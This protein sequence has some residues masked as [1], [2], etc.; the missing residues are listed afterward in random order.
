MSP[1]RAQRRSSRLILSPGCAY[2]CPDEPPRRMRSRIIAILFLLGHAV[3]PIS[4]ALPQSTRTFIESY[5]MQCHDSDSKKGGLDFSALPDTLDDAPTEALW[6]LVFD[7]VQRAEMPPRKKPQPSAAELE[8]F[9]QSLGGYLGEHDIARHAKTGRVPWRRLNRLEYENTVH[10][11]LAIDLPLAGLLPEDGSAYGFDNVSEG[12]RLSSSQIGAYLIAADRALD[13]ALNLGPAPVVEKHHLSFL[14][15]PEIREALSK[16]HGFLEKDGRKHQ[17]IYRTLPDALVIFANDLSEKGIVGAVR[18]DVAGQYRV[19]LSAYAFQNTDRQV[20]VAKLMVTNAGMT[21]NVAA[22][23]LPNGKPRLVEFTLRLNEGERIYLSTVGCG[24]ARD[25]TVAQFAG[26]ERFTGPGIAI[27]WLEVE[28]PLFDSWPPISIKKL[29]GDLPLKPNSLRRNTD[30]AFDVIP[31]SPLQ[32]ADQLINSFA[33]KAF[34]R[35]LTE[36]DTA[37]YRKLTS[38]ALARGESLETALRRAVKAILVAPEFLFLREKPGLLD[39]YALASRLAYFLWSSLPDDELLHLA[40]QGKLH[41]QA[42]LRSQTDRLLAHPKS[43]SFTKNFC[44]QWLELRSIDAT[45]PDPSLY[46][47]FDT[48]LQEAMVRE[49]ESFFEEMLRTDEPVASFIDSNFTMLNRRLAEHYEIPGISGEEFRR[50]TLPDGSHRG[51]LMT[52]ASILKVTANGTLSSPVVRGAWILKHLLGH[53]LPPPPPSVGSIEPDTRG[54]AT[55]REQLAKHRRSQSCAACHQ[56]MDPPGFALESYDAIGGWRVFYRSQGKGSPVMDPLSHRNRP[57]RQGLPVD[58]SGDLADGRSFD[59][60]EGLKI[61]LRSEEEAVAR[62]FVNNLVAYATGAGVTFS[63]R[64]EVDAIL[65]RTQVHSHGLRS[66]VQE[67]VQSPLFQY[68]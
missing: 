28:G 38:D 22:F 19:R 12:L 43:R 1:L 58:P 21:R 10:D 55:I 36:N 25:G 11:L 13:S 24:I 48:L 14:D 32:D 56:Y 34:R 53:S 6:T 31:A 66:L 52:H 26:A 4:A 20:V 15:L 47:E 29:F 51:G 41:E 65:R 61:L 9:F 57:Y 68:K 54:A 46:P 44:G 5:C 63:D 35:P 49:T 18:A 27:Q 33:E 39:D 50:V 42:V 67:V 64:K 30:Q 2:C 59:N 62:N 7:R 23:D 45:T 3:S 8:G 40:A 16:P 17:Q 60:I 37:R